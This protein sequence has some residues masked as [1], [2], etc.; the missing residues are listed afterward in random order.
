[1]ATERPPWS[2]SNR[3]QQRPGARSGYWA[4][5]ESFGLIP[6]EMHFWTRVDIECLLNGA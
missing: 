5:T 6:T 1:M 4:L 2:D 3:P